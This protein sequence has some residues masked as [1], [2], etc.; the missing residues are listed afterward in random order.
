MAFKVPF[1]QASSIRW[2]IS[3][4]GEAGQAR[5]RESGQCKMYEETG[6]DWSLCGSLDALYRRCRNHEC[7][8]LINAVWPC[9]PSLPSASQY[10]LQHISYLF[11]I[12]YVRGHAPA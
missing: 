7:Q 12:L 4:A 6:D 1:G 9:K 5:E 8:H 10:E 11:T 2:V 3:S